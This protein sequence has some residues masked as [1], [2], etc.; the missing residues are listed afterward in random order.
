MNLRPHTGWACLLL[1]VTLL[2]GCPQDVSKQSTSPQATDTA[3]KTDANAPPDNPAPHAGSKLEKLKIRTGGPLPPQRVPEP[4]VLDHSCR[5]DAD[6]AVKDVGS[7]CGAFPACVNVDSPADPAAV[8]AE[9]DRLGHASTCGFREIST[10]KCVRGSC[11]AQAQ[12]IDPPVDPAPQVP[13]E[14]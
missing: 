12:A 9:C 3:A 8:K 5:T 6:C 1:A 2:T 4:I 7:C 14:R 13:E 10:C 11:L